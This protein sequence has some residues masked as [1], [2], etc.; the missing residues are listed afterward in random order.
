MTKQPRD[1]D[2][3]FTT[4]RE[5]VLRVAETTNDWREYRDAKDSERQGERKSLYGHYASLYSH[6]RM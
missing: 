3:K 4:K 1:R 6:Y 2:G 5:I